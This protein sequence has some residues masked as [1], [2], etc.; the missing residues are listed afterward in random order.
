MKTELSTIILEMEQ[1]KAEMRR[2]TRRSRIVGVLGVV[3]VT[4]AISIA[5][6]NP[7]SAQGGYGPTLASL[8]A[9]VNTLLSRTQF[10]TADA[11]TKTMKVTGCNVF[12]QSGS[13]S[14]DDNGPLSGLGNLTIGYNLGRSPGHQTGSHNLIIGDYQDYSSWGGLVAGYHNTISGVCA[15]ITGGMYNLAS[16]ELSSVT[17]GDANIASGLYSIATGGTQNTASGWGSSITGGWANTASGGTSTVC[18][19]NINTAQGASSVVAS[20]QSNI[21]SGA[22]SFIASGS[23]NAAS[24]N[25]SSVLGGYYN[26]SGGESSSI[27]GGAFCYTG[28]GHTGGDFE[29]ILGGYGM[30]NTTQYGHTP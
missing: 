16:G 29:A 18:G 14:T 27:C 10:I 1:L 3:M 19:G 13:G 9:Q 28:G 12:I 21:A 11:P 15:T 17:G 20:G 22:C 24:G 23:Q 2:A 6:L 30:S 5:S 25:S 8:Q 4:G 26:N 7:V